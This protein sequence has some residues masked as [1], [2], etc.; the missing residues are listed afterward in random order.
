MKF[1]SE[2]TKK[3][4]DSEKD[5]KKAEF[6]IQKQN[7]EKE[8]LRSQRAERAKEVEAA[9]KKANELL[10]AFVNDYGSFHMTLADTEKSPFHSLF[11]MFF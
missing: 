9:Y 3:I 4:Y 2:I 7:E 5:L 6:E 10:D 8:K 1:Y 11:D